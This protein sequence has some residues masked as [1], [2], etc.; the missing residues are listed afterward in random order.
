MNRAEVL[1]HQVV[2]I[3]ASDFAVIQFEERYALIRNASRARV[4]QRM[5]TPIGGGIGIQP[6]LSQLLTIECD[7][8]FEK[9]GEL[10]GYCA[11]RL[12]NR[13]R[14]L[15]LAGDGI[16]VHDGREAREELIDEEKILLPEDMKEMFF[17]L[18]GY[19]DE[20]THTDNPR[21]SVAITLRLMRLFRYEFSER[22]MN[23][24]AKHEGPILRFVTEDEI[25]QGKTQ[26][27]AFDIAPL[28]VA[29]L[30]PKPTLKSY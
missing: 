2:R 10:R 19:D 1:S 12:A 25:H 21:A 20:L 15:F 7:F 30:K 13:I 22:V 18:A 26:D 23:K 9:A 5:L 8:T 6:E 29:L 4:G 14:E 28:S 17:Q 16:E 11:G 27:K 3:S 24:L